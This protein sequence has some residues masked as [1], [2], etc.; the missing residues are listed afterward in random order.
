MQNL[1]RPLGERLRS[2]AERYRS[3]LARSGQNADGGRFL[4]RLARDKRGTEPSLPLDP[5]GR[6]AALSRVEA[7]LFLSR[8]PVSSRKL[9]QLAGLADGTAARTLVRRLNKLYDAAGTAFRAEELAGGFQLLSRPKFGVWL[10]KLYPWPIET[11]LSG[12]ALETLAVVAY[13]QPVLRAA[14]EAV[15]G[16]DCGEI[17]RQLM[18]RDL[19]R[20]CG[21]SDDLGR[22]YLYGTTKRFLQ[23]FGLRHLDDLPRAEILRRVPQSGAAH[24]DSKQNVESGQDRPSVSPAIDPAYELTETD[25]SV[26]EEEVQ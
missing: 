22:P 14:V 16:V 23:L 17:L 19:L 3:R 2:V 25:E 5:L 12:P 7:V 24:A 1:R 4:W 18:E 20:I 11:R 8:E 26:A 10:R 6:D 13:R 21:R 15:R 9:A